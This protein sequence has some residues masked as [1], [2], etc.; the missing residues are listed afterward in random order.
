MLPFQPRPKQQAVL[1]YTGGR[2]GVSAVPGSGKTWTLSMLAAQLIAGGVLE[3]DQEVLVVTLVN[4]AVDNFAGRVRR[5]LEERGLL[6]VGYR[7]RTLHGLCHDIVR[8]RPALAGLSDDFR[9]IDDSTAREVLQEAADAWLRANPN[10][11]DVY[12]AP[13]LDEGKANWV[14]SQ[15]WPQLAT[16]IAGDF[17]KQAKDLELTPAELRYSLEQFPE[18]LPLVEMG[19][20]IYADYQRSLAYRGAVD[21]DDLIRLAL[22]TLRLDREF[23]ERLRR[24]WPYILEDEAQDSSRLQEAIL[25]L[26]TGE[27]GNWV[28]VGDP[29]QAIYETFTTASPQ[30]LRDFLREPG[31]WAL[32]LPNSGRSTQSIMDVANY[33]V[34]WTGAEHPVP[35]VR[36]A[37]APPHIKPTPPGD[38]QP[39]PPD[40]PGA[41][42]FID[43]RYTPQEEL[44]AV[45]ESVKRWLQVQAG[46]PEEARE[47]CALLTPR[48]RRGDELV[49][50]LKAAGAPYIELLRSTRQTRQAAGALANIVTYLADPTS[51]NKLATV[52]R[53]WR[54]RDREDPEEERRLTWATRTLRKCRQVEDFLW[55]RSGQDWLADLDLAMDRPAM[56]ERLEAFRGLVR[57]WQEATLLPIDQLLLTLAQDIFEEPA[58]LAIAHKLAVMLRGMAD[59]HGDWR[60]GELAQELAAVALN[61]RKFIGMGDDDSGFD[62]DKYRGQVVVTTVH[63]AKGLEWDRVYLLS[64]N[65]YNFPSALP[66]DEFIA[67]KWFARDDLNLHA[68]T[69]EQLRALQENPTLFLYDEGQATLRARE[70]Y[71]AERLRLL[72]VGITRARRALIATWNTGKRGDQRPSVPFVALE[73]WWGD[74]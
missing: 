59:Q 57:R 30:F 72:Y 27:E 16:S 7:V 71:A 40:D 2:M 37:L 32:D 62:P 48:N 1:A 70:D 43:R 61:K 69:L 23:L 52:Y 66:G 68:E 65:A 17:I 35:A 36:E 20:A 21:F 8:E 18:S 54:R 14:R 44:E 9:V 15:Q 55:P 19:T 12:L 60:L 26:L 63:K 4:S 47:T 34:D 53:V 49:E 24:R 41:I 6:A 45:V 74:R 39:N 28:R 11:L 38:P 10:A 22:Q 3:D 64:V 58:D 13:D 67:E 50:L 73:A 29:N 5:F 33:F 25:R 46:K 42:R 56:H 51:A 31:V